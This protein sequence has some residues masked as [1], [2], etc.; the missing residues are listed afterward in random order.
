MAILMVAFLNFRIIMTEYDWS[1]RICNH[2]SLPSTARD[3]SVLVTCCSNNS[4]SVG[5]N[6]IKPSSFKLTINCY[7]AAANSA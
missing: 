5:K 2:V 1:P 6:I 4:Y 7:Y 3:M